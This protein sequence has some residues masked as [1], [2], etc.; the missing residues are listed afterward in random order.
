[1]TALG[2]VSRLSFG[3]LMF[4]PPLYDG[5]RNKQSLSVFIGVHLWFLLLLNAFQLFLE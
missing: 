1:M 2:A 5:R 4:Q 3:A